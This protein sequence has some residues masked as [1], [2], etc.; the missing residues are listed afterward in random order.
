MKDL[1]PADIELEYEIQ[2]S[3][4]R[5]T[6][7]IHA[8]DGSTVGRFGRMGIDL[9]NTVSEQ[10]Q[11]MPQCRLCT[12]GKPSS[13]DWAIFREKALE[14]WGVSVPSDAFDERLLATA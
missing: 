7:W 6:I 2:L 11:G 14:W 5:D 8:S 3:E 9:H 10:M 13:R 4:Q 12:H 1:S